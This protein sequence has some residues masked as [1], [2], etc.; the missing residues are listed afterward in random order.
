MEMQKRIKKAGMTLREKYKES[1]ESEKKK[2]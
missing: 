2:I 1:E